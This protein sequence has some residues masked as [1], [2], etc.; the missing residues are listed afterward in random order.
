MR[1]GEKEGE[2]ESLFG[3]KENDS[4]SVHEGARS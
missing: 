3:G 1:K 4:C 2:N